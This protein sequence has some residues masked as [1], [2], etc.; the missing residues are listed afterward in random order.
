MLPDFFQALGLATGGA[1]AGLGVGS[2]S[3]DIENYLLG[4]A[5]SSDY[6]S[7]ICIPVRKKVM[8]KEK[9]HAE[10]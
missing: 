8:R 10:E 2:L 9:N 6:V 1:S 5:S 7:E 4:D 3:Y